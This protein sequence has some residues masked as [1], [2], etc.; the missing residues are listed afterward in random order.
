[1]IESVECGFKFILFGG[2]IVD[3]L[4]MVGESHQLISVKMTDFSEFFWLTLQNRVIFFFCTWRMPGVRWVCA[5]C[6]P[7]VRQAWR[8]WLSVFQLGVLKLA[9]KVAEWVLQY[10]SNR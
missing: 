3:F 7:G 10:S 2:W 8:R 4:I 5:G 1:M 6:A 9:G